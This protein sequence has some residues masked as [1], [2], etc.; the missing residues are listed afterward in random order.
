[1]ELSDVTKDKWIQELALMY[2]ANKVM[3]GVD[4]TNAPHKLSSL[5]INIP[6]G[7][8][9]IMD[10]NDYLYKD[11][12][13]YDGSVAVIYL[14]FCGEYQIPISEIEAGTQFNIEYEVDIL[15]GACT[16]YVLAIHPTGNG[17]KS[18]PILIANG[19]CGFDVPLSAT[20][21]NRLNAQI[22]GDAQRAIGGVL[23]PFSQ[24][25]SKIGKDISSAGQMIMGGGHAD[26]DIDAAN[27][28]GAAAGPLAGVATEFGMAAPKAGMNLI[29]QGYDMMTRP[30]ISMPILQGG[31]GW[32]SLAGPLDA[33]IQIRRGRYLYPSNYKHTMGK[34][35]CRTRKVNTIKGYAECSNIDTSGLPCTEV[36]RQMIKRTLETGFYRK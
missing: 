16:A 26:L 6:A 27:F 11:F 17:V 10:D 24:A 2:A 29:N 4:V 21:A 25:A 28:V 22:L 32:A 15:S 19:Q 5:A 8:I 18:Y 35:E 9:L 20:N 33:Y 34:P 3:Y 14:P 23:E 31:R 7:V 36:E 13:D 12:R 1:M 30:A